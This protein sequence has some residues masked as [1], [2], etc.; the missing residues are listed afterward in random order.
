MM[1]SAIFVALVIVAASAEKACGPEGCDSEK[2]RPR[3]SRNTHKKEFGKAPLRL[4]NVCVCVE[5][6]GGGWRSKK[7]SL[8]RSR[9]RGQRRCFEGKEVV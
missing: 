6:G 9:G 7:T 5:G 3:V 2:V 8:R 1:K 4:L